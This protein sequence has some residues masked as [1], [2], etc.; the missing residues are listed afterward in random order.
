MPTTIY[1][2]WNPRH[3]YIIRNKTSGKLYIGQ[4]IRIILE[5]YLGS[6]EY[7]KSHCERNGGYNKENI[8]VLYNKYY[9]DK[10][11]AQQFLDEVY[12][13]EGRYWDKGNT[14]WANLMPETT[15]AYDPLVMSE[16]QKRRIENGTHHLL[17][18]NRKVLHTST[19]LTPEQ[20]RSMASK[21]IE[22]GTHNIGCGKVYCVTR[23][24]EIVNIDVDV[25][26][27]Q[28]GEMCD[29]DYVRPNSNEGRNRTGKVKPEISDET[30]NKLRHVQMKQ[31]ESGNHNLKGSVTCRNKKGKVVQVPKEIYYAQV[32][33]YCDREYVTIGS[34]EGRRRAGKPPRYQ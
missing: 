8:E 25:Y 28:Q 22:G 19:E 7:W 24:G 13:K 21:R 15:S 26:E 16:I 4:T 34:I 20:A 32:G 3:Y 10:N 14:K 2:D 9:E 30:K 23:T 29:W 17:K 6:G 27:A 12:E 11:K 1:Q 33:T 5:E 18:E 31:I